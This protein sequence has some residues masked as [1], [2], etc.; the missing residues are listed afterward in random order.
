MFVKI[1][2]DNSGYIQIDQVREI[3]SSEQFQFPSDAL[4]RIFR[5]VLGID[6]TQ[7]DPSV[8]IKYED[9]L[10]QMRKEFIGG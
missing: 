9:F 2:T 7:I 3:L 5:I 4:E 6:L 10:Q 8:N 1:D